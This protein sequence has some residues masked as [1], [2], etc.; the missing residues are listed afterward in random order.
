MGACCRCCR[1]VRR[2]FCLEAVAVWVWGGWCVGLAGLKCK[3]VV[4]CT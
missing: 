2:P 1:L 3:R 4:D